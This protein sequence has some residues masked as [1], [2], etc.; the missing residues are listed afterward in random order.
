MQINQTKIIRDRFLLYLIISLF[1]IYWTQN[2]YAKSKTL[3]STKFLLYIIIYFFYFFIALSASL[4]EF[5]LFFRKNFA[6]YFYQIIF[7]LLMLCDIFSYY[8]NVCTNV[9]VEILWIFLY[10]IQEILECDTFDMMI[11]RCI[12]YIWYERVTMFH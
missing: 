3:G 4:C 1:Q 6:V 7:S 2:S 11:I 12:N 10:N 8:F 5:S 9:W